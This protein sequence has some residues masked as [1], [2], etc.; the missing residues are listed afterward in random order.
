M[1]KTYLDIGPI[2]E[3]KEEKISSLDFDRVLIFSLSPFVCVSV[4]RLQAIVLGLRSCLLG[5]R[6]F[7][8][9]L[10]EHLM[11]LKRYIFQRF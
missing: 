9:F 3:I 6:D 8:Q 4:D 7:V 11:F 1:Y 5:F 10:E 2:F